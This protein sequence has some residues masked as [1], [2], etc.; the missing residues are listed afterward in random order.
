MD[1]LVYS[2]PYVLEA[3][4]LIGVYH[5]LL[6]LYGM[7]QDSSLQ[8]R[9][10]KQDNMIRNIGADLERANTENAALKNSV[11]RLEALS[12]AQFEAKVAELEPKVVE[13]QAQVSQL[14]SKNQKD[15]ETAGTECKKQ[16]NARLEA[17][18]GRDKIQRD[19]NA[20]AIKY[21][22]LERTN[23]ELQQQSA[24]QNSQVSVVRTNVPEPTYLVSYWLMRFTLEK[25]RGYA[26][27]LC[28]NR[29]NFSFNGLQK[30]FSPRIF[31]EEK[32]TWDQEIILD[33]LAAIAKA[34][35]AIV[36]DGKK[37]NV[38]SFPKDMPQNVRIADDHSDWCGG[39]LKM[40]ELVEYANLP[41]RGYCI[42]HYVTQKM[43][44][45]IPESQGSAVKKA[46]AVWRSWVINE[47]SKFA[48][49]IEV[50]ITQMLLLCNKEEMLMTWLYKYDVTGVIES[51]NDMLQGSV[52]LN[53]PDQEVVLTSGILYLKDIVGMYASGNRGEAFDHLIAVAIDPLLPNDIRD[54]VKTEIANLTKSSNLRAF[55]PPVRGTAI[56]VQSPFGESSQ[57]GKTNPLASGDVPEIKAANNG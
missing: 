54:L 41:H 43:L 15:M 46:L 23:Q 21:E 19:L 36:A 34:D 57:E 47:G 30:I 31:I 45:M 42:S 11:A 26:F 33:V 5:L 18:E 6:H 28:N 48:P 35:Q 1:T 8:F 27:A 50:E 56:Q 20:L 24:N 22:T 10:S 38:K 37:V 2:L 51:L 14:T 32:Q 12:A 13:L 7:K 53:L 39:L 9:L 40:T 25:P 16:N 4:V 3:A 52:A 49:S 44:L 17:E 29:V 55:T